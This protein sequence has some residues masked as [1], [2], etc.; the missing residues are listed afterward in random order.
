MRRLFNLALAATPPG[1]LFLAQSWLVTTGKSDA[2]LA[3]ARYGGLIG[4]IFLAFDGASGLLP[5]MMR[6]R[7]SMGAIRSAYLAYRGIV[8][9][10]FAATLPL[11]WHL[12]PHETAG[13]LPFLAAALL[14]RLP[15]L[16]ADLDRRGW[17]HWSMMLQNGWTVPLAFL[18]CLRGELDAATAGHAALWSTLLL[19]IVHAVFAHGRSDTG[20]NDDFRAPLL[21]ILAFMAAQGLGQLYGRAVLFSLGA[22]FTGP[23]AALVI[24]AK[25]TFNAAGLVVTYL[26]RIE[27]ARGQKAI[28]LSL[29]GQAAIGLA[30]GLI[31]ASAALRLNLS[32]GLVLILIAWQVLEKLSAN[33]VYATQL[34]N[35][36]DMALAALLAVVVIGIGGLALAVAQGQALVFVAAEALAYCGVLLFWLRM[37]QAPM[38]RGEGTRP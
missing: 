6:L 17:H 4:L 34:K 37:Q 30:A 15:L 12:A 19:F 25:Q 28:H 21:E 9:L 36:H 22:A 27:L 38:P 29:S 35:R 5:A 33:A 11:A 1:S 2:V 18:A 16:D 3:L 13:L 26:R 20:R 23:V 24:Y 14:L 10:L 32:S 7:H 31:V 8:A